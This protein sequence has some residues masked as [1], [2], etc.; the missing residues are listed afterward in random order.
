MC[1]K[2]IWLV[3]TASF[4]VSVLSQQIA[5]N[6]G[7]CGVPIEVVH[8]Y[9]DEFPQGSQS[10][11]CLCLHSSNRR[12]GIAVSSTGRKFSNYARSLD[13]KNIAY[14]GAELT[15]NNTETP[16]P[17]AAIVRTCRRSSCLFRIEFEDTSV[18]RTSVA[19]SEICLEF[20]SRRECFPSLPFLSSTKSRALSPAR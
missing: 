3:L 6:P 14:T 20:A 5:Q 17:S 16:Y 11:C 10:C 12:L 9:N 13:P 8:L 1:I 18:A 4:V 15:G 7:T 2:K 19:N